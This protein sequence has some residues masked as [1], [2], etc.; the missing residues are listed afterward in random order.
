MS[1]F[2][3]FNG[4]QRERESHEAQQPAGIYIYIYIIYTNMRMAGTSVENNQVNCGKRVVAERYQRFNVRQSI[5][6]P[7]VYSGL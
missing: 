4:P 3:I 6:C 5:D 2:Y 7:Q 1:G